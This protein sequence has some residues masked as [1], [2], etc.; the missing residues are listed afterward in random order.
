[1]QQQVLD[2]LGALIARY[3]AAPFVSAPIV[4]PSERFFPEGFA[5]GSMEGLEQVVRRLVDYGGLSGMR[6][7]ITRARASS[8]P[9][10]PKPR[11]PWASRGEPAWLEGLADGLL[12][13]AVEQEQMG[14]DEALGGVLAREVARAFRAQRELG[15]GPYRATEDDEEA[16]EEQIDLTAVYLG[17]GVIA[18]YSQRWYRYINIGARAKVALERVTALPP[19]TLA[20]AIAAQAVAR[21]IS[22]EEQDRLAGM[23]QRDHT[24]GFRAACAH[25]TG[26]SLAMLGL[27]PR[28]EWPAPREPGQP[29]PES[30]VEV[31]EP[32][33]RPSGRP[34]FRVAQ[35]AAMSGAASGGVLSLIPTV[36]AG[37]LLHSSFVFLFL[38]VGVV[39]GVI[40]GRKRR[41]DVC[42]SCAARIPE[43]V[44]VCAGCGGVVSGRI[45]HRDDRLAAEERLAEKK[46]ADET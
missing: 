26:A 31:R 5:T 27:P 9:T 42:S 45:D 22:P 28:E 11:P 2:A 34:V 13:F 20:F 35:D 24:G 38:G 1:V 37:V 19:E 6:V 25:L 43:G 15:D 7:Q 46:D 44:E 33:A 18:S 3:G 36:V 40:R 30:V 32:R 29:L 8:G 14:K 4:E 12:L 16:S 10:D 21:G 39:A 23:L 17:L 41:W